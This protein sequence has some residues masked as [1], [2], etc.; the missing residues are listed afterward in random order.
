MDLVA[1][2]RRLLRSAPAPLP[3]AGA[4]ADGGID[5][6]APNHGQ[7]GVS[8][9]R[10]SD[11]E[12]AVRAGRQYAGRYSFGPLFAPRSWEPHCSASA[13]PVHVVGALLQREAA[14]HGGDLEDRTRTLEAE[15]R[16]R[17]VRGR[18]G[19]GGG[20]RATAPDNN[21]TA[22]AVATLTAT[23]SLLSHVAPGIGAQVMVRGLARPVALLGIF[24]EGL[25]VADAEGLLASLSTAELRSMFLDAIHT[26]DLRGLML[27]TVRRAAGSVASLEA[28]NTPILAG[29]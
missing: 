26:P 19:A 12:S 23:T 15:T 5:A 8:P 13:A 1:A 2:C 16:Q 28:E 20:G 17:E 9:H 10:L 6:D 11:V 27:A 22:R 3:F 25:S 29:H 7:D 24:G 4:M 18:Q 21:T 14:T